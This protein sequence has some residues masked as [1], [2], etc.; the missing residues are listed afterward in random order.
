MTSDCLQEG[1]RYLI[2]VDALS[3]SLELG[4]LRVCFVLVFCLACHMSSI[5]SVSSR[6]K[7]GGK[8]EREGEGGNGR[9]RREGESEGGKSMDEERG[10]HGESPLRA[11]DW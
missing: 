7:G 4:R 6:E 11:Y 8:R 2:V 9:A 3:H 10:Y 1:R 5:T